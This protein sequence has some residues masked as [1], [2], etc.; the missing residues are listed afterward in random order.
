MTKI[1]NAKNEFKAFFGYAPDVEYTR[2]DRLFQNG[3]QTL[4]KIQEMQEAELEKVA[5]MC[6]LNRGKLSREA[7]TQRLD[8]QWRSEHNLQ[9]SPLSWHSDRQEIRDNLIEPNQQHS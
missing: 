5:Q 1:I 7:K 9:L 2:I 4:Q 8:S 6:E 3:E